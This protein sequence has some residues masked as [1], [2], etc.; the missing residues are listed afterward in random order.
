MPFQACFSAGLDCSQAGKWLLIFISITIKIIS[1]QSPF[2]PKA[3]LG[4][5]QAEHRPARRAT[6]GGN[7]AAAVAQRQLA[8][9]LLPVSCLWP[10]SVIDQVARQFLPG[11]QAPVCL[12][13]WLTGW[14]A[15]SSESGRRGLGALAS[16]FGEKRA[17]LD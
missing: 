6:G 15:G 13:S 14:L 3:L 10:E 11:W 4:A 9:C 12:I 5:L 2:I 16:K 7:R 17:L 1:N 8:N